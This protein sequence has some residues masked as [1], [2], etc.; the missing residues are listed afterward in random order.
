MYTLYNTFIFYIVLARE[1]NT[2]QYHKDDNSST[3]QRCFIEDIIIQTALFEFTCKDVY[4][5]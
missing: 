1:R 2:K 5:L 3:L 4:E